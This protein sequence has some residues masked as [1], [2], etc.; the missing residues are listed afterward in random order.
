MAIT[1][2]QSD[3]T[4]AAGGGF[5][6]VDPAAAGAGAGA[7]AAAAGQA[8][9]LLADV[10]RE[11]DRARRAQELTGASLDASRQLAD[12]EIGLASD[13]DWRTLPQR[14]ESQARKIGAIAAQAI[15]DPETRA[16][17]ETRYAA[18]METARVG[19]LQRALAMQVDD[20]RAGLDTALTDY[21]AQAA[22]APN[23]VARTLA[24]DEG[25]AAI[26]RAADAGL[27]S[28]Q[29][30]VAQRH[31]FLVEAEETRLASLPPAQAAAEIG[32]FVERRVPERPSGAAIDTGD[33]PVGR[34]VVDRTVDVAGQVGLDRNL[35][36]A[37]GQM[38]SGLSNIPTEIRTADGRR[39]SDATGPWQWTQGTWTGFVAQ[40]PELG[41]TVDGRTDP[42][43]Q[44]IATPVAMAEIAEG[45]ERE[46]GRPA[47]FADIRLAWWLG[48]GAARAILRNPSADA[49]ATLVAVGYG[50]GQARNAI[51]GHGLP[52]GATGADAVAWVAAGFRDRGLNPDA[53]ALT[54]RVPSTTALS[55]APV[56]AVT[57]PADSPL[58]VI[59]P[60]RLVQ[61]LRVYE[62]RAEEE[63]RQARVAARAQLAPRLDD[64]LAMLATGRTSPDPI[65]YEE[66]AAAYGPDE[67]AGIWNRLIEARRTG[68]MVASV[69][70]LP[71]D[72]QDA[73]LA[74]LEPAPGAGFAE[75]Q[76]RLAAVQA[77]VDDSRADAAAAI[78]QPLRDELAALE[79]GQAYPD[80]LT[81]DQLRSALGVEAGDAAFADLVAMRDLAATIARLSGMTPAEQD[82]AL[83]AITPEGE[84]FEDK[85]ARYALL[86]QAIQQDRAARAADGAAY[87]LA[88][89]PQLA[90]F[91][92]HAGETGDPVEMAR[93]VNLLMDEQR[94]LGIADPRPMTNEAADSVIAAWD[95]LSGS[96]R[97]DFVQSFLG[98]LGGTAQL[99]MSQ[100]ADRASEASGFDTALV[101]AGMTL[102][103]QRGGAATLA[104]LAG[105][106]T[107]QLRAGLRD[108]TDRRVADDAVEDG[109]APFFG[110]IALNAGGPGAISLYRQE[111]QRL[112]YWYAGRGL[113]PTQAADRAVQEVVG[114]RYVIDA[115][116]PSSHPVR[117]PRE[118]D[119]DPVLAGA[120]ALLRAPNLLGPLALTSGVPEAD[121]QRLRGWL[122]TAL[123]T[124]GF[125][126]TLPDDS[127]LALM[128][129]TAAGAQQMHT[130]DGLPV[131]RTWAQ[132][133]AVRLDQ[134]A[135]ATEGLAP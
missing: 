103:T 127:G 4:P 18:R 11:S 96:E 135:P 119:A 73:I 120:G 67:V 54:G 10:K 106:T 48:D 22:A 64:E 16:E 118:V 131:T 23:G 29:E 87:V 52:D 82:A 26:D 12:L 134:G 124:S 53:P 108:D 71:A 114:A 42:A 47:T 20:G 1:R 98:R 2:F 25:L 24:L 15:D 55:L 68:E 89:N 38:E 3:R 69:R 70:G 66:I 76:A 94:R 93:V 58:S 51:Q 95:R 126:V 75:A 121:Q 59:P 6:R 77:A 92:R 13:T 101:V 100:L 33:V 81:Q 99:A 107:A 132:L 17:F 110:T 60:A 122:R 129:D 88:T 116:S 115:P 41:L 128:I 102:R 61:L 97:V 44:A 65:D 14:F 8:A 62:A 50:T 28:R 78:A 113:A 79:A 91:L 105:Q 31:E 125:W 21:S 63:Q 45:I 37:M 111:V 104:S 133:S 123:P 56:T 35:V 57:V 112:A 40:H 90:E 5:A 109:L 39:M 9:G 32:Q 86:A 43:Q 34:A 117:I 80:G 72:Q 19:M 27:I 49:A 130:P 74:S 84:D 7:F 46:F 30:Q 36:I 83:A 85:A